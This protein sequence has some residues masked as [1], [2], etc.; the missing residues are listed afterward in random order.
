MK[1]KGVKTGIALLAALGLW[2]CGLPATNN[3][4]PTETISWLNKAVCGNDPAC[5][6]LL[7]EPTVLLAYIQSDCNVGAARE[8]RLSIQACSGQL[9]ALIPPL[10]QIPP[11][12]MSGLELIC[13]TTGYTSS[14]NQILPNL[15]LTVT[16]AGNCGAPT[17]T[18]LV[19]PTPVATPA[20]TAV[21]TAAP[22]AAAA[23][24]AAK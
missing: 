9:A 17:T 5:K 6:I 19:S 2:A 1:F 14:S 4:G 21:P 22:S 16:P 8:Y 18:L 23:A 12:V 7:D 10:V 13:Q 11:Q 20:P 24:A 3:A 15:P